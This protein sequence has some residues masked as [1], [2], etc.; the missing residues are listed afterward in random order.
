MNS[1]NKREADPLNRSGSEDEDDETETS[2][3]PTVEWY[4]LADGKNDHLEDFDSQ[5]P[6]YSSMQAEA[7]TVHQNRA[8]AGTSS[9]NPSIGFFEDLNQERSVTSRDI[10]DMAMDRTLS[11]SKD[12]KTNQGGQE[13]QLTPQPSPSEPQQKEEQEV[14]QDEE[15]PDIK[16][17]LPR[18]RRQP[19]PVSVIHPTRSSSSQHPGDMSVIS[20]LEGPTVYLN[21]STTR[22]AFMEPIDEEN[23]MSKETSA[24][25]SGQHKQLVTTDETKEETTS[26]P[27]KRKK[28]TPKNKE[29]NHHVRKVAVMVGCLGC[30]M[31]LAAIVLLLL[32]IFDWID[33]GIGSSSSDT[34]TTDI[35][36]TDPPF[37][38]L[39]LFP[40]KA[41]RSATP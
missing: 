20:E 1:M 11:G 26:P 29:W 32:Y 21:T 4:Q 18:A 30:L 41:P 19:P 12:G 25:S 13:N 9:S 5:M 23:A 34:T 35:S 7:A 10:D 40:P 39:V 24:S 38:S 36:E 6:D 31:I 22:V 17:N 16:K 8:R 37:S 2:E 28:K 3:E 14:F 27:V 15:T 33:F